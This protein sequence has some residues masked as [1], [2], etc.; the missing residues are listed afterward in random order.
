VCGQQ[1][2]AHVAGSGSRARRQRRAA[3][4]QPLVVER[5]PGK[6]IHI[7]GATNKVRAGRCS[8][9]ARA[10]PRTTRAAP[11]IVCPLRRTQ[12]TVLGGAVLVNGSVIH[13]VNDLLLPAGIGRGS[14][15]RNRDQ[16]AAA[17]PA[18]AAP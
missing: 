1:Q 5:Q 11:S 15:K 12:A 8:A 4:A 3:S 6:K 16:G 9:R 17:T 13:V 10:S 2:L 7:V 14:G 18:A